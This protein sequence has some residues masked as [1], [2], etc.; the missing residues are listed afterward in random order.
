MSGTR[1]GVPIVLIGSNRFLGATDAARRMCISR[2]R[3]NVLIRAGRLDFVE[4]GGRYYVPVDV[5]EDQRRL[6]RA[7]RRRLA[8]KAAA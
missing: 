8:K 5:V 4:H 2:Q 3:L 1:A 7:R 6:V